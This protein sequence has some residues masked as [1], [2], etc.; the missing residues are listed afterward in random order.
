[1][2]GLFSRCSAIL[3]SSTLVVLLGLNFARGAG[4]AVPCTGPVAPKWIAKTAGLPPVNDTFADAV[5]LGTDSGGISTN[6]AAASSEPGEPAHAGRGPFNS[7]WWKFMPSAT[8]LLNLDTHGSGFNTVLGVYT[9]S[10]VDR[11]TPVASNDNDGS[12]NLNSGL[13]RIP[14]LGSIFYRIVVASYGPSF[15]Y[16]YGYGYGYK[17][18]LNWGY[19]PDPAATVTAPA[20]GAVFTAPASIGIS[21]SVTSAPPG[22]VTQVVFYAGASVVGVVR[23]APW[24]CVWSNAPAGRYSLQAAVWDNQGQFGTSAAV[25]I[26]VNGRPTADPKAVTTPED[27][28]VAVTLS[29]TD[30]EGS[31]LTYSVVTPPG[32][33]VLQGAGAG[34]TYLPATNSFGEDSFTYKVN[35]G[36]VDS[37]PALVRIT[38]TPVND[39]PVAQPQAVAGLWNTPLNIVLRGSD[40]E[41]SNLTFAVVS[42]PTNGILSGTGAGRVYR[43]ATNFAGTDAFTFKANDG[44]LDSALAVVSIVITNSGSLFDEPDRGGGWRLLDW[45]GWYDGSHPPWIRH[46]QHDWL[47]LNQDKQYGL[48]FYSFS[49]GWMWT[50]RD[51]YPWIVRYDPAGW[52]WYLKET[53]HP[54]WFFSQGTQ[55]WETHEVWTPLTAIP[56]FGGGWRYE[57][58]FGWYVVITP[59]QIWHEQHGLMDIYEDVAEHILFRTYDLGWLWVYRHGDQAYPWIYRLDPAGWLC[60]YV[61]TAHPRWFYNAS[62]QSW[63]TH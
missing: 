27:T 2:K 32:R 46:L 51:V 30:P 23:A 17:C 3:M 4:N 1:M 37:A 26:W 56:D 57:D 22:S 42:G 28:P 35:D 50:S 20:A 54:R 48:M 13:F 36:L 53:A 12:P 31:N 9:G 43:P 15:G 21:A 62:T 16:G 5:Q 60:Y 34:R 47:L 63:E 33:G 49:M 19:R 29:G 6:V 59:T 55:Q 58:W 52:I 10:S 38:V 14:V 25:R 61:G 41:G 11:L 18:N 40:V 45:F 7:L 44:E 8:G 39:P 24:T